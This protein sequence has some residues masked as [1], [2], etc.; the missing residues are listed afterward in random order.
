V[1][2]LKHAMHD[3]AMSDYDSLQNFFQQDMRMSHVH[4]IP[5]RDGDLAEPRVGVRGVILSRQKY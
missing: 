4:L 3:E 5:R 2:Q 1:D